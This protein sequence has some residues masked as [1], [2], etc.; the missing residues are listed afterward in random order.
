MG[1]F[2][3]ELSLTHQ[4]QPVYQTLRCH[5]SNDGILNRHSIILLSCLFLFFLVGPICCSWY[6]IFTIW[7]VNRPVYCLLWI[8]EQ[9]QW[10]G[11][12]YSCCQIST[13][14]N[15]LCIQIN[16]FIP[17]LNFS[18]QFWRAK[19][20]QFPTNSHICPHRKHTQLLPHEHST[21]GITW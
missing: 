11:F 6:A 8:S 9:H 7:N 17:I 19:L 5:I 4:V 14:C 16:V 21:A 18:K 10:N 1:V 20:A 15:L 12:V 3:G 13:K 2:R